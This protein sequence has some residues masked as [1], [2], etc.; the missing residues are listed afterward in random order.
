MATILKTFENKS[1]KWMTLRI[2]EQ[3]NQTTN[4]ANEHT[5]EQI[6][7]RMNKLTKKDKSNTLWK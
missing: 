1:Y 5:N 6:D 3:T 4:G 7:E 2:N